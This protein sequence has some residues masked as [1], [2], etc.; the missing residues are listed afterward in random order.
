[1]GVG[2]SCTP[3]PAGKFWIREKL[4]GFGTVYGPLAFGTSA[5]S[6][7]LTDW[8]GG[9]VVGIHGTNQPNL[10]PGR[11]S[12]GCVRLKNAAILKLNRLMP[13]GTPVLIK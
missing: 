6:D 3:T 8:P 10:I 4:K 5:Y 11:P 12:H 13:L 2:K 1:M 9:G 7:E